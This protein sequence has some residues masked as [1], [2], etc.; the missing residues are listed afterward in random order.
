MAF[1]C[2]GAERSREELNTCTRVCIFACLHR[3]SW[4]LRG[5]PPR[6]RTL[7]RS[8]KSWKTCRNSPAV[9]TACRPSPGCAPACPEGTS[10]V[11]EIH[12]LAPGMESLAGTLEAP[13][14]ESRGL[15][16]RNAGPG[17]SPSAP[18]GLEAKRTVGKQRRCGRLVRNQVIP[19]SQ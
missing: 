10:G 11:L 16:F 15:V 19:G 4:S 3:S 9:R 14:T 6:Q 2:R 12:N 13:E 8:W 1:P 17:S 7:R 5:T 18:F